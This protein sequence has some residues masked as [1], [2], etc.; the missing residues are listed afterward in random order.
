MSSVITAIEGERRLRALEVE[1]GESF[2]ASEEA[3]SRGIIALYEINSESLWHFGKD[4]DGV[5]FGDYRNPR[6]EDYLRHFCRKKGISRSSAQDHIG[7]VRTWV[8]ALERKTEELQDV[9]VKRAAPI[10]EI[11]KVDGRTGEISLPRPEILEK[12]PPAPTPIEQVQKK[13]D[14]VLIEPKIPLTPNDVRESFTIDIGKTNKPSIRFSETGRGDIWGSY[15]GGEDVFW[16]GIVILA[17][18]LSGMSEEMKEA[19]FKRLRVLK[20]ES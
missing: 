10:K 11:V 3:F 16:D 13:I 2:H 20:Y 7:T 17:G 5:R 6:F 15:D 4:D 14:E 9:G 18:T 19:I 1:A 8:L 12:L